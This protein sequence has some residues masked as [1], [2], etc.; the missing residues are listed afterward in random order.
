MLAAIAQDLGNGIA[1]I[2]IGMVQH[3]MLRSSPAKVARPSQQPCDEVNRMRLEPKAAMAA[4]WTKT[5]SHCASKHLMK[6]MAAA[7]A[8][9]RT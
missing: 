3:P 1:D 5:K 4:P 2:D 7:L 6:P 9:T 8:G